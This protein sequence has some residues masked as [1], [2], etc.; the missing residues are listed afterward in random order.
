MPSPKITIHTKSI[1]MSKEPNYVKRKQTDYTL[2]LKLRTDPYH[3]ARWFELNSFIMN[4]I[5]WAYESTSTIEK[6][7]L[8]S[9]RF[10]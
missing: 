5:I 3:D 10:Y 9:A 8:K 7:P 4:S 2:I 1:V 6:L